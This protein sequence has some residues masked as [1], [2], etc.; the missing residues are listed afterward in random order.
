M[1]LLPPL[2]PCPT[3]PLVNGMLPFHYLSH[4]V[5]NIFALNEHYFDTN[6]IALHV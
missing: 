5:L 4:V 1:K 3:S 2:A 6:Y